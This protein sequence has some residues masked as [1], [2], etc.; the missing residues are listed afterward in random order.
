MPVDHD[1]SVR[2][3]VRS[4][5]PPSLDRESGQL[6]KRS[7]LIKIPD[8]FLDVLAQQTPFICG[9]D[10]VSRR[11]R[12]RLRIAL[13][14][15]HGRHWLRVAAAIQRFLHAMLSAHEA[16]VEAAFLEWM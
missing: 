12:G 16:A 9:H 6:P 1:D 14:R 10:R 4:R 7:T 15:R 5:K 13:R 11:P 2:H 8:R 3:R